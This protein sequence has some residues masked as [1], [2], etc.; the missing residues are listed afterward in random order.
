LLE[1][2]RAGIRRIA[3]RTQGAEAMT[4]GVVRPLASSAPIASHAASGET[5]RGRVVA[6]AASLAFSIAWTLALGKDVHWDA[7]NYHLYLGFS[8]LNDR[9]ALDFF[10][11][12]TPSY[13]NPY[14]YVPL[15]LMARAEWPALWMAL[16][17]ASVH[18]FALW[19]T[20]EIAMVS[21]GRHLRPGWPGFAM[22]AVLLAAMNPVLLQGIGSTM[23]D[24]STGVLVLAGWFGIAR[25]LRGGEARTAAVAGIL[26]GMAAALKLSN[27]IFAMA[28]VP[29]LWFVAG[30]AAR[31]VRVMAAFCAACGAAFLAIAW[32]WA[33][34][35]WREFGNPFF[36]FLNQYFYSPDFVS[37]PIKQERFVPLT[38]EAFLLRP[39]EMLAASSAVH[40]EPRAPDLR[41]V[42][43]LAAL[44]GVAL[45]L[46]R[47]RV[48]SEG[49]QGAID[50]NARRCFV[51]LLVG[52]AVAWCIWLAISGNSR[53]F[54]PMA[55]VAS[56]LVALALQRLHA[57]WRVPVIVAIV[58]VVS[59]QLVQLALGSDLGR[60][61]G[62]WEGP[63]LRVEVPK[64]LRD[65]PYFY[66]APGFMSGS[67]FIPFL[68]SQSGM[69]NVGGFNVIGPKHPGGA[70]LQRLL[71]TNVDRLRL[72]LPLPEG[73]VDRNS[74]PSPP[75]TL[76]SYFRRFGL[77]VDGSDCEFLRFE[78]NLRGE[79]RPLRDRWKHFIT[80]R[81]IPAPGARLAYEQEAGLLDPVF[82]RVEDACPNLFFPPR[83]VTQEFH[84][85][86]RTYHLGSEMQLFVD[87][88]RVKYFFYLRGGDPIDIGSIA[89]WQAGPQPIDCSRRTQPAFT[90]TSR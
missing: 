70:R 16:V 28:A 89:D 48:S 41:Y 51:G 34:Q 87:N 90:T 58:L 60:N 78:G 63:W 9:F 7:I 3:G 30:S 36:P 85:W 81:L 21:A 62:P 25:T 19:L 33:W 24:L 75:E 27:A 6:Y 20:F 31:R 23:T 71:D 55:C 56:V 65:H 86:S 12:G 4:V 44:A 2:D 61:G 42:A 11:A 32:P 15:Y 1:E 64:K 76:Q 38:W 57:W 14:A 53:Y 22:L 29:A 73:A 72:L 52:F 26:C 88:G 43:L 69:S 82:D 84:Y 39:F 77:Q 46:R 83:A 68:H 10:G 66:L 74:L 5:K 8:A 17:F 18:A 79:R 13:I 59:M 37:T 80:C 49:K 50:A 54:L 45:A 40:V 67:A 47:S 35:L